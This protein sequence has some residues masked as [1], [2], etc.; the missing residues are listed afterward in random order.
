LPTMLAFLGT[1]EAALDLPRRAVSPDWLRETLDSVL[2]GIAIRER[3]RGLEWSMGRDCAFLKMD[4]I[5]SIVHSISTLD[6]TNCVKGSPVGR[7]P[8][9]LF[10]KRLRASHLLKYPGLAKPLLDV[11]DRYCEGLFQKAKQIRDAL[12][13]EESKSLLDGLV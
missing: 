11:A 8:R 3:K 10:E 1:N 12:H 2:L 9:A 7:A 4:F 5:R 6:V 13:G